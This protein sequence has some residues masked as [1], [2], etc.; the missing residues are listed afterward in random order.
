[1][2]KTYNAKYGNYLD[3]FLGDTSTAGMLNHR[4]SYHDYGSDLLKGQLVEN[5]LTLRKKFDQYPGWKPWM[6]E[7][8]VMTG[9]EGKGGNGR[10]RGDAMKDATPDALHRQIAKEAFEHVQPGRT[11]RD[12]VH[13]KALEH[14]R[15]SEEHT[16]EL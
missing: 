14:A 3:E 11:G 15:R 12:A 6:S 1:M 2:S 5:R 9:S 10:Q 4:F 8:C 16:S 13:V 7:Y